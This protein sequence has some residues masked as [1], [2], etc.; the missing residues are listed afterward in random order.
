MTG[1]NTAS[2]TVGASVPL[3]GVGAT[4]SPSLNLSGNSTFSVSNLNNKE[5]YYGMQTPIS[6]K[7]IAHY[8]GIGVDPRILLPLIVS[9]IEIR[10]Q[11]SIQII[12][13]TAKT[14]VGFNTF[15]YAM[16][17][18]I[19]QGMSVEP[20]SSTT[21]VGPVLDL[22]EAKDP[23]F[24][25]AV[26]ASY[27][28]ASPGLALKGFDTLPAALKG[29]GPSSYPRYF[30]L[31]KSSNDYRLCWLPNKVQKGYTKKGIPYTFIPL[32][33]ISTK[34]VYVTLGRASKLRDNALRIPIYSQY[35]CGNSA[36]KSN[37]NQSENIKLTLRSVE[38]VIK[39]LGE[40]ARTELGL[41]NPPER[42][43]VQWNDELGLIQL[44]DVK[45]R[46]ATVGDIGAS[47]E[48]RHF[49]VKVSP[50]ERDYTRRTIELVMELLALESSAKDLPALSVIT[51]V[52]R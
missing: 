25:S 23:K 17:G 20:V 41:V 51:L 2:L 39:F 45:E 10:N 33:K 34:I 13:N 11:N 6:I 44:F 19:D 40:M 8:I 26:L 38:G 16:L 9:D 7:T 15:Y 50:S 21:L 42:L 32:S 37:P 12:H 28:S 49:A 24:L 3:E 52:G 14:I 30:R 29:D 47:L 18:L 22:K 27:S 35:L 31:L 1:T 36:A 46:L 4:L 43:A 48:Y 5:F